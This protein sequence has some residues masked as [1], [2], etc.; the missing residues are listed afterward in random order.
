MGWTFTVKAADD[1]LAAAAFRSAMSGLRQ[2]R[3]VGKEKVRAAATTAI[4]DQ[5]FNQ[6]VGTIRYIRSQVSV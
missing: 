4:A 5:A 6:S 3:L 2:A 1:I